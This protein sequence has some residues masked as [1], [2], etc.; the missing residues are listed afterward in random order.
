MTVFHPLNLPLQLVPFP[1]YPPS[2]VHVKLP[3]VLVQSPCAESQLSEPVA[4]SSISKIKRFYKLYIKHV[5]WNLVQYLMTVFY[6]LNLPLQLV[7]FPSYPPSQVHVKLPS[8]LVQS[9]CA[10]SQLSEPVK[11][12]SISKTKWNNKLLTKRG[13]S[14]TGSIPTTEVHH[15]NLPVQ[16]V[17]SPS[18]P[19][20]QVQVKLPSVLVQSPCAESQLSEPVSHSSISKT[21]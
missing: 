7:P 18:Y 6:S 3:S 11:H 20:S 16:D 10:E 13:V 19:P 5:V 12:S 1:S 4:H 14:E 2:Q 9:P 15:L 17:P 8:V 21:T